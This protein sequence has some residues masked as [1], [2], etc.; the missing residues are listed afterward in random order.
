MS[1]LVNAMTVD[2]L[3]SETVISLIAIAKKDF[4]DDER[5]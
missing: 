1:L 3:D 5:R 4:K 2:K